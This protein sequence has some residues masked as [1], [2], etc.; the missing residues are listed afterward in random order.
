MRFGVTIEVIPEDADGDIDL[1][2]LQSM[3]MAEDNLPA[4]VAVTHVP[5]SSGRVYDAAAVGALTAAAGVPL[6]LDACQ[7]VGQMPI[8]VKDIGCD[9]LTATGRKYLRA[10]RGC[11]FLYASRSSMS[12]FMPAMLDVWGAELQSP[13]SFAVNP[14]ARRYEAY[15]MSFAAKVGLAAAV[16]YALTLSV[17]ATWERIQFLAETLRSELCKVSGVHVLDKGKLLCGIVSFCK[18]GALPEEIKSGLTAAGVNVSVSKRSSTFID[19]DARGLESVVRA[20]VHYY[21][22]EEEIHTLVQTVRGM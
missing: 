14:T 10:P 13:S 1:V 22:T 11:G 15:E 6:L 21:N 4:L 7:S 20:S 12:K 18:D 16:Q 19:F 8:D 3:L 5:T 17:E 9:F 2:A